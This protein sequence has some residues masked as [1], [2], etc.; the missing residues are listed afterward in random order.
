LA[1]KLYVG[2]LTYDTTEEAIKTAFSAIGELESVSLITDKR[3][4]ESKGFAF[5]EMSNEAEA[6]SAIEQ[7]NGTEIDGRAMNVSI[8][9]PREERDSSRGGF[10]KK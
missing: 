7:L 5:V 10:G 6:T 4:G 1:T 9:R 2:N 8:A 3:S